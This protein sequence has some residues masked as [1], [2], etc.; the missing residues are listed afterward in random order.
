MSTMNP[1][2]QYEINEKDCAFVRPAPRL[3]A[4]L[5]KAGQGRTPADNMDDAG[6]MM[7][8]AGFA[9]LAFCCIVVYTVAAW[10][11][12]AML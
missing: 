11:W 10:A 7:M 5:V 9:I 4:P 2:R 8:L 3:P 6:G 1:Y 12:R